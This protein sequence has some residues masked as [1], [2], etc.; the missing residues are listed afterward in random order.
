MKL[1]VYN[2]QN[3]HGKS[4]SPATIRIHSKGVCSFNATAVRELNL[5][6]NDRVSLLQDEESPA[7]WYICKSEDGFNLRNAG[8][9]KTALLFNNYLFTKNLYKSCNLGGL[10]Y[11]FM[12]SVTPEKVDGMKLYAIIT[13]SAT[14]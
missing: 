8:T 7:N 14:K 2:E 4:V 5:K 11:G 12:L 3:S 13:A 1:K 9:N 10:S 6:T